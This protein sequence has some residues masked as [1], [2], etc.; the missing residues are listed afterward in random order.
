MTLRAPV[1]DAAVLDQLLRR[2]AAV[3]QDVAANG[4]YPSTGEARDGWPAELRSDDVRAIE[5][6]FY[7]VCLDVAGAATG[8]APCC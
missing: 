1:D 4:L 7:S 8:G 2:L 3:G 5:E 6:S